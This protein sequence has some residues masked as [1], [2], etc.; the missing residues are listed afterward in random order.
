MAMPHTGNWA[1]EAIHDAM[2]YGEVDPKN[3]ARIL[4]TQ[5]EFVETIQKVI[6]DREISGDG[7]CGGNPAETVVAELAHKLTEPNFS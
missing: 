7:M 2:G 5:P 1:C 3:I 4:S 6:D